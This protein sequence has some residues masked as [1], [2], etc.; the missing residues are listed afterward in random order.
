MSQNSLNMSIC[1]LNEHGKKNT[2]VAVVR[3][4][5]GMESRESIFSRSKIKD[6]FVNGI[7]SLT[8]K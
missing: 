1:A 6:I 4:T 7:F 5:L 2:L 3:K 8:R